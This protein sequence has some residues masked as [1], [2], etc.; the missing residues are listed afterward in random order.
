MS[1]H[2]VKTRNTE[3]EPRQQKIG[4]QKNFEGMDLGTHASCVRAS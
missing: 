3:H 1:G 2:I 4:G